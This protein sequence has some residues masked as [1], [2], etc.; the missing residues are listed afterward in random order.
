MCRFPKGT[1]A[2]TLK[3]AV[4]SQTE[5][6]VRGTRVACDLG[7]F[8]KSDRI[9][10]R[11]DFPVVC[12]TMRFLRAS[13]A[14][15]SRSAHGV[16]FFGPVTW[17]FGGGEGKG[18]GTRHVLQGVPHPAADGVERL[19]VEP[20]RRKIPTA[21]IAAAGH[22]GARKHRRPRGV[23][24]EKL[25]SLG[26]KLD[27]DP[28]RRLQSSFSSSSR[29]LRLRSRSSFRRLF[30]YSSFLFALANISASS[31]TSSI[32][33][34]RSPVRSSRRRIPARTRRRSA[35]ATAHPAATT[36]PRH[37]PPTARTAA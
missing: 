4:I 18:P 14:G 11:T 28:R 29:S 24:V 30:P 16:L 1:P 27:V 36:W 5:S 7:P 8:S 17:R 21:H 26:K 12:W 23:G 33:L 19:A 32:H 34:V 10:L 2:P 25:S 35:M 15:P 37:I 9:P 6:P 13:C 20:P 3:P 22:L 31:R